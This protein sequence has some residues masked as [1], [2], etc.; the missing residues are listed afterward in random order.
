MANSPAP[1]VQ[2]QRQ[3]S[4]YTYALAAYT[5]WGFAPIYFVYV[6]FALPL[7]VLAH[8]VVWSVPLVAL[9]ITIARLWCVIRSMPRRTYFTLAVCAFLLGINWL[10]FIYT[11][12]A[13]RIV[14]TS[15]GYFMNPLVSI[16]LGW[17]FLSERLR[18]WQWA[19]VSMAA[20]GVVGELVTAGE[21]PW[22]G[23]LLA[24]SFGFYG[25]LRKQLSLPSSVGLG[26]ETMMVVP[27][28]IGYLIFMSTSA[29]MPARNVD[30]ILL[31]GLGGL[32][33]V[34]PLLWFA[35]AAIRIP[36]TT[37]GFFQYLA[38]SISLVLGVFVYDEAVTTGRWFSL[39]L[40]W[41]ALLMFSLESLY[42]RH[43]SLK[44]SV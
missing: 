32:V 40:I 12:Q 13:G 20:A 4:G 17:A 25:L 43:V 38:P 15:L 24:F 7:E 42:H 21:L 29:D 6:S 26:V 31:L 36:L 14:E 9:L 10:T 1:D 18:A 30:E 37:L 27:F 33:T 39:S 22:L 11:V 35:S 28:A 16:L 8:R 5:F 41:F 34:L 23:L 2:S 3:T 19:A 44:K